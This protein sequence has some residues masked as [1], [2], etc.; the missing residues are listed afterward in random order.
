VGHNYS[1]QSGMAIFACTYA[2][3]ALAIFVARMFFFKRDR[4]ES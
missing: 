4:V 3:G 1:L 2:L